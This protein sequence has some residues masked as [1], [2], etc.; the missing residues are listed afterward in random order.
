MTGGSMP[1]P[2]SSQT[3]GPYFRIGLE[4]LI[5]RAPAIEEETPGRFEIQGRVLERDGT[6]VP[7]AMLE[8][9]APGATAALSSSTPDYDQYPAGFRRTVTNIDGN[10]AVAAIRPAAVALEDGRMQ[11]PHMLV[12]V[13]ARGLLRHLLTR[14]YFEDQPGNTED[15]LL[16]EIPAGR[17]GTL[18]A[19]LENPQTSSYR[20]NVILQGQDETVFFAW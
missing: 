14:V 19:Q 1:I 9:W 20:W 5:D 12:L 15:P 18:M 11:A 16:Q 17:R 4:Y 6:P 7:D 8:F 2:A 13:F 3:V 10:F